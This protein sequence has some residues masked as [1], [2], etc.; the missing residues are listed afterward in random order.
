MDSEKIKPLICRHTSNP[1]LIT[2]DWDV[3]GVYEINVCMSPSYIL[4]NII[5]PTGVHS[6]I[7]SRNTYAHS[8]IYNLLNGNTEQKGKGRDAVLRELN[9]EARDRINKFIAKKII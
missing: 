6:E 1:P 7:I 4:Y 8:Q 2:V 9:K 3:M 5:F